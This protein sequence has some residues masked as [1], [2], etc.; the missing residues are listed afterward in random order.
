V[1]GTR[2]GGGGESLSVKVVVQDAARRE[3]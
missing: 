3:R 1:R 2:Y